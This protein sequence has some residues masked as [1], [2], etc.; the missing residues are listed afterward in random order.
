MREVVKKTIQRT[1]SVAKEADEANYGSMEIHNTVK[2]RKAFEVHLDLSRSK[3]KRHCRIS[4]WG[5]LIK[6]KIVV[7]L[8]YCFTNSLA[9]K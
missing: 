8:F 6:V 3:P 1:D 7:A 2:L 5:K 9:E 4:I